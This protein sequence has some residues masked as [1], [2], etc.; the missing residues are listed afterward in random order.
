[1]KNL[2]PDIQGSLRA[3]LAQRDAKIITV[4][5]LAL[6]AVFLVL[7]FTPGH[8]WLKAGAIAWAVLP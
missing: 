3:N 6:A 7:A 2:T 4:I 8:W 1:M 5:L